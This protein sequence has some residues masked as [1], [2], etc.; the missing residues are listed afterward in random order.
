MRRPHA[1][2]GHTL[3]ELLMVLGLL[4]MFTAWAMHARPSRVGAAA[5]AL[6]TQ[7]LQARFAAVERNAPVAVVYRE[8]ERSFV[9]LAAGELTLED[10]CLTG[11]ELTRVNLRDFRGVTVESLPSKGIVWLPSGTG[12]TCGGGGAFNQTIGLADSVREARVVISRAGRVR[13]EVG[14]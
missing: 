9:A 11:E 7:L 1:T 12:R 2:G 4:G 8:E 5:V 10:A 14:R 3:L 13:S 6:R